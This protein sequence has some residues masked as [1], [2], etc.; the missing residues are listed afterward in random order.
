MKKISL[1]LG[2]L[3]AALL[4][5]AVFGMIWTVKN[6]PVKKTVQQQ[7]IFS[8]QA[9]S[10]IPR[11]DATTFLDRPEFRRIWAHQVQIK[12][13]PGRAI[14]A[15]VNHHVL[16]SDILATL[17]MSLA[18]N[19]PDA[20]R[21]V[22]LSPDHFFSG[23][24]PVSTHRRSYQTP[25]GIVSIDTKAVEELIQQNI[26]LDE[27]GEMYEKEHGIGALIPFSKKAFPKATI[28]PI[29]I[30]ATSDIEVLRRLA[31]FLET[32]DDGKTLFIIS[33]D[34]SHYLSKEV[35]QKNDA[36]TIQWLETK[37][38]QAMTKAKDTHTDS[39]RQFA[40]L[41][42]WMNEKYPTARFTGLSQGISSDYVEDELNTTSYINGVWSINLKTLR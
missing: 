37:D 6:E 12:D 35:A 3:T 33:A 8:I 15:T 29:S 16:A 25:D 31:H 28:V 11:I 21:L 40:T 18:N 19:R 26:A 36:Q 1:I 9:S 27:S 38:A 42:F 24:G 23:R 20:Q 2:S 5:V 4:G 32:M 34:M 7:S 30:Q 39:G 22:I 10:T 13:I 14:A 41:F 17:F